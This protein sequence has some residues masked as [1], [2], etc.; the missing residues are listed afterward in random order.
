MLKQNDH[1]NQ[2]LVLFS[3]ELIE[4]SVRVIDTARITVKN[5]VQ[6]LVRTEIALF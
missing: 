1:P 2:T 4:P 6:F 5:Y 3:I